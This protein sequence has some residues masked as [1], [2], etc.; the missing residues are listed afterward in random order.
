MYRVRQ[1]KLTVFNITGFKNRQVFLPHP[2]QR[3][4]LRNEEKTTKYHRNYLLASE[5]STKINVFAGLTNLTTF[6]DLKLGAAL[7]RLTL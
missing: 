6:S 2:V 7:L 5:F 3:Y 1:K 4:V